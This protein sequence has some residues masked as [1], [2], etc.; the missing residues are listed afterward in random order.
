MTLKYQLY[1]E[2]QIYIYIIYIYLYIYEYNTYLQYL[3][4]LCIYVSCPIITC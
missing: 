3:N 4:I 2:I 1:V